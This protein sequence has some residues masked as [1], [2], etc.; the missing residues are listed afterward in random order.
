MAEFPLLID[1]A[2][3]FSDDLIFLGLSSDMNV[4]A[5][6]RFF[7]KI[8][9]VPQPNEWIAHDAM[10]S[11]TSGRFKVFMLPETMLIDQEGLLIRK[12]VGFDWSEDEMVA[13][14]ENLLQK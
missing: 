1:I 2:E 12:Y 4:T 14:I 11:V 10:G 6:D 8:S 3:R 5:I 9:Y 13:D 7:K